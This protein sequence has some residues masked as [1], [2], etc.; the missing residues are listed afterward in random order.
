MNLMWKHD[1]R[2]IDLDGI[3]NNFNDAARQTRTKIILAYKTRHKN[4]SQTKKRKKE[5]NCFMHSSNI[6]LDQSQKITMSCM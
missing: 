6:A 3:N 2:I 4:S 1:Y 5:K